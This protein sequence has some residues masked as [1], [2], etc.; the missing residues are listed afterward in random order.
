MPKP[1]YQHG[2]NTYEIFMQFPAKGDT[3]Y[4]E[5]VYGDK[6][7]ADEAYAEASVWI[8]KGQPPGI[9]MVKSVYNKD[10]GEFADQVITK[11]GEGFYK[12]SDQAIPEDVKAEIKKGGGLD[13]GEGEKPA[14][15][16]P[17]PTPNPKV[18]PVKKSGG[19]LET[20]GI[21]FG[22]LLLLGFALIGWLWGTDQIVLK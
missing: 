3:W 4:I 22:I 9:R 11:R 14:A 8:Y 6:D 21:V 10:T 5:G 2:E 19:F 7:Q 20:L 13:A 16:E 12:R 17:R 18:E 1:I 15:P